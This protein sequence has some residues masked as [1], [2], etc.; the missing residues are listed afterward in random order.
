MVVFSQ[1][2][3]KIPNFKMMFEKNPD[4]QGCYKKV[5]CT[6]KGE[7]KITEAQRSYAHAAFNNKTE[8]EPFLAAALG[9]LACPSRSAW[10]RKCLNL[11]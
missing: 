9:P 11:T 10:P 2:Y 1:K 5:T 8:G 6:R 7:V 4:V 3:L